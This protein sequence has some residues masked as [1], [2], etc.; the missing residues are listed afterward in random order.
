MAPAIAR[1]RPESA[2][3]IGHAIALHQKG[4]LDEA[5]QIYR[6]ILAAAPDQ[7]DALNLLGLICYQQGR[8]V[9]ALQLIG[10]A[11]NRAQSANILNNF[12]LVLAALDRHEEALAQFER[13]LA[14]DNCHANALGNRAATLARLKRDEEALAAYRRLLEVQPGHLNAL[15]EAGGLNVRLGRAEA[16][17]ACYDRAIAA[18]PQPE[19]YVNK[20]TALRALNRDDEALASF[21]AALALK[22]DFAEAHWNASLIRLRHGDFAR[23]WRDY[24]LRLC[25]ADWQARRRNFSAPLWLGDVP[26]AGKTILLHAEQGFGDTL[27]FVR[28]APLVAR[29]GARVILECQPELKALLS[30]GDGIA[31]IVARGDALP[32]FDFHCPLLSLPLAFGTCL[33]TIPNA[34]PYLTAPEQR[35]RQWGG[36]L[37][38][39][40]QPRV[41]FAWAGNAA[42]VNDHNRSI[43]L[44]TLAPVLA[45]AGFQFVS[46]QKDAGAADR[47]LLSQFP[48]VM[49]V[50]P[51]FHDFADTASVV[52]QLDLVVAVDT[53]IVHL[54]GAMGK[55][56]ALLL[57]F[58]PDFRWLLVR[59]DSPWY[60][61]MRIFR[62]RA[63]GDW[64]EALEGL[65]GELEE[66]TR[67]GSPPR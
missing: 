64:A 49:D 48:N 45:L 24:E 54:A 17:L 3:D 38:G 27:Q 16:A 11:L 51:E 4:D 58:S 57:P 46:L 60:P 42:H 66:M 26:I 30:G 19:L 28:Y 67:Q 52:A 35:L 44:R 5:A 20:G 18:A 65:R 61:T 59:A 12:A 43:A 15:N 56:V 50:A 47:A 10:A 53:S 62:Q 2:D 1:P 41:G 14:I 36:R 29:Q 55:P 6:A 39:L 21:A 37:A 63:I 31:E 23:G 25:K 7:P 40:R 9:E 33:D 32:A 22:P 13:A 34:V 8:N